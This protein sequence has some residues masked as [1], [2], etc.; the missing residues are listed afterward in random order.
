MASF[1]S[2][3]AP[4]EAALQLRDEHAIIAMRTRLNAT[5]APRLLS[6]CGCGKQL[7]LIQ[8]DKTQKKHKNQETP[9]AKAA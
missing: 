7:P 9:A 6:T 2:S 5:P 4:T 1:L 8:Q 3:V